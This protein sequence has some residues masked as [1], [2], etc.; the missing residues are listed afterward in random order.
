MSIVFKNVTLVDVVSKKLRERTTVFV[1]GNKIER[2]SD[3]TLE[4]DSRSEVVDCENRFLV[5]GMV[6]SHVHLDYFHSER[7]GTSEYSI[8]D[9][10][11]R[12]IS[13]LHSYLYC[14]VTSV[15]DAGND[16]DII[17]P[18]RKLEREGKIT[19]PR[20]YCTGSLITCRGGHNGFSH[21][22]Y[23]SSMPEDEQKIQDNL[24]KS[25]DHGQSDL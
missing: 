1:R 3:S 24:S 19:S 14:G 5:P 7:E 15:Y 17:F 4:A 16:P 25:P 6:D 10:R 13:R 8:E 23:I 22:T 21:T 18:L 20:I 2:I 11:S 9:I 12:L